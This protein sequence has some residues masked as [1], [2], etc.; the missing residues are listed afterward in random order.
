MSRVISPIPS[1]KIQLVNHHL[2]LSR[3]S[4]NQAANLIC[5]VPVHMLPDNNPSFDRLIAFHIRT[6]EQIEEE[7]RTWPNIPMDEQEQIQVLSDVTSKLLEVKA[8]ANQA[9][10]Y[11]EHYMAQLRVGPASP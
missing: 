7:I 8:T 10:S 4:V 11:Y 3:E 6:L 1:D 2:S 5:L 9:S